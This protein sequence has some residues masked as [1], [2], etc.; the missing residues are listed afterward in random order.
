V[1]AVR[2]STW[3]RRDGCA[4]QRVLLAFPGY[5]RLIRHHRFSF[6]VERSEEKVG[7]FS[8]LDCVSNELL[9]FSKGHPD[10]EQIGSRAPELCYGTKPILP[11]VRDNDC[12]AD[13]SAFPIGAFQVWLHVFYFPLWGIFSGYAKLSGFDDFYAAHDFFMENC[14]M[15]WQVLFYAFLGG[16]PRNR[17][18]RRFVYERNKGLSYAYCCF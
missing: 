17:Q 15:G 12:R 18:L 9:A 6:W 10:R 4:P 8:L 5:F 13:I 16:S 2:L 7:A 1:V 14:D 11:K 3:A